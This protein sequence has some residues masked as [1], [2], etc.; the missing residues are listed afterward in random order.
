[1]VTFEIS[2]Q[3]LIGILSLSNYLLTDRQAFS[4]AGFGYV[5]GKHVL[6]YFGNGA[7]NPQFAAASGADDN[8]HC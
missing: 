7:Q 5:A 1:M 8:V 3:Y 2:A 4:G 6:W